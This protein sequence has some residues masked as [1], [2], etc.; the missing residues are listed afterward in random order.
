[1][2]MRE[3]TWHGVG[4]IWTFKRFERQPK[5]LLTAFSVG[6]VC[7]DPHGDE[8]ILSLADFA[9][10]A[11]GPLG[12]SDAEENR[13][14]I[15]EDEILDRLT[16]HEQKMAKGLREELTK[17][18]TGDPHGDIAAEQ[19][20]HPDDVDPGARQPEKGKRRRK[21]AYEALSVQLRRK[22]HTDV[23]PKALYE[24]IAALKKSGGSITAVLTKTQL[25]RVFGP[26][27]GKD[28]RL[29][30]AGRAWAEGVASAN[31]QDI[32]V[33]Y[34]NFRRYL[35]EETDLDPVHYSRRLLDLVTREM[36]RGKRVNAAAASRQSK[37]D[38][39][40]GPQDRFHA[41]APFEQVQI[42]AWD[43]NAFVL[44]QYGKL[45]NAALLLAIDVCTRVVLALRVVPKAYSA[46]DVCLLVFNMRRGGSLWPTEEATAPCV[47][48]L[49]LVTEEVLEQV[50][51][52]ERA[53]SRT[54]TDNGLQMV[55][56]RALAQ[57]L[58]AGSSIDIAPPGTGWAKAIVEALFR[59]LS[60]VIQ[61]WPGSKGRRAEHRGR[62]KQL[63][64]V[65][66]HTLEAAF[67]FYIEEIY[68]NTWHKTLKM[69]PREKFWIELETAGEIP[70]DED[71]LA[72]L[73]LLTASKRVAN[74]EGIRVLGEDFDCDEIQ[75]L[76][77][78]SQGDD[79][80][81]PRPLSVRFDP[82]RLE[83]IW[84]TDMDGRKLMVPNRNNGMPLAPLNDVRAQLVRDALL[85]AS[86]LPKEWYRGAVAL[87]SDALRDI[88]LSNTRRHTP[89]MEPVGVGAAPPTALDPWDLPPVGEP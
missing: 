59:R 32:A 67:M 23:R 86:R 80:F 9:E 43:I 70:I 83:C 63:A 7:T 6:A 27:H 4:G 30:A 20:L 42:D 72:A 46:E 81:K 5:E 74:D 61:S 36:L 25:K 49:V 69:T 34:E 53:I 82:T 14:R 54:G 21:E 8:F 13:P 60:S 44:D 89:T 10:E 15:F 77:R 68:H 84:V 33:H 37:A 1:M 18:I 16:D 62:G 66:I 64:P 76:K 50:G 75:D 41:A 12:P 40:R 2:V 39:K 52:R 65:D 19:P 79:H 78:H 47:P 22:G 58:R 35:R 71:P 51:E 26:L 87:V 88:A 3:H 45:I 38:R 28:P 48:P 73:N 57:L 24:R 11:L 29:V 55:G 31:T 17:F 85:D 56:L